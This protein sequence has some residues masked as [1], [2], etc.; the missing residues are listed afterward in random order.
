MPPQAEKRQ[1]ARTP[2][3]WHHYC[4]WHERTKAIDCMRHMRFLPEEHIAELGFLAFAVFYEV[5]VVIISLLPTFG[6]GTEREYQ[7]M[8]LDATNYSQKR[9]LKVDSAQGTKTVSKEEFPNAT[10]LFLSRT[11]EL[12][13]AQF[14]WR[15]RKLWSQ[16][17]FQ[18]GL[19][20]SLQ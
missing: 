2:A 4:T 14:S 11:S 8:I 1:P 12:A 6:N 18:N 15:K 10:E 9:E 7:T 5:V 20:Q 17:T 16:M 13:H 19:P 3:I